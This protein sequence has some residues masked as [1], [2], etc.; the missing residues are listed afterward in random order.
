[1]R[2][3]SNINGG[4]VDIGMP[5]PTPV[6]VADNGISGI[7]SD[8][9]ITTPLAIPIVHIL[10]EHDDKYRWGNCVSVDARIREGVECPLTLVYTTRDEVRSSQDISLSIQSKSFLTIAHSAR[11]ITALARG[12]TCC[13]IAA[14]YSPA[15]ISRT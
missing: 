6:P 5:T 11:S 4:F 3:L 9:I 10:L 13:R 7:E 15:C 8:V 14:A 1:V 2:L 12:F